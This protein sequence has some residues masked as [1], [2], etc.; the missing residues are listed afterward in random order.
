[1]LVPTNYV[2]RNLESIRISRKLYRKLVLQKP[3]Q[4]KE[5]HAFYLMDKYIDTFKTN[6]KQFFISLAFLTYYMLLCW[7]WCLTDFGTNYIM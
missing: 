6:L 4:M 7:R 5:L 2:L 3:L 1:L